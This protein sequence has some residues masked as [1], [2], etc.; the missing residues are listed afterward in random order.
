M[1][2]LCWLLT[3]IVLSC[4]HVF[5]VFLLLTI[6]WLLSNPPKKWRSN[7]F[8]VSHYYC[9]CYP[10][11]FFRNYLMEYTSSSSSSSPLSTKSILIGFLVLLLY[12][13]MFVPV[14][15]VC[16]WNLWMWDNTPWKWSLIPGPNPMTLANE[17]LILIDSE[18]QNHPG[19]TT[20]I[21]CCAFSSRGVPTNHLLLLLLLPSLLDWYCD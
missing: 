10:S 18:N 15:R 20:M 7:T 8:C 12:F 17:I 16:V 9:T 13:F 5:N 4:S 6:Y 3:K 21:Y 14:V 19:P 1:T 11:I 2:V